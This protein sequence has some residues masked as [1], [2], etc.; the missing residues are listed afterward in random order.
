MA[1]LLKRGKLRCD[2]HNDPHSPGADVQL[3]IEQTGQWIMS[4]DTKSGFLATAVSV[5]LVAAASQRELFQIAVEHSSPRNV[6]AAISL[7]GGA[8]WLLMSVA[9]IGWVLLPRTASPTPTRFSWPWVA[10]ADVAELSALNPDDSRAEAWM[11]AKILAVIARKKFAAFRR[12]LLLAAVGAGFLG[13]WAIL[14]PPHG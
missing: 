10:A 3:A 2:S 9:Q 12:A 8:I 1:Q 4:A 6:F 5:L 14:R 7:V 11:H 13:A